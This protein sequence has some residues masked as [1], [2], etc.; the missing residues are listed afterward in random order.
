[1]ATIKST[2]I[3]LFICM[4]SHGFYSESHGPIPWARRA[5]VSSLGYLA[6]LPHHGRHDPCH[7]SEEKPRDREVVVV[8]ALVQLA[9]G[10]WWDSH[11]DCCR[12]MAVEAGGGGEAEQPQ[13]GRR[14]A[15]RAAGDGGQLSEENVH[16]FL[17]SGVA[18]AEV[19]GG[20]GHAHGGHDPSDPGKEEARDREEV[21]VLVEPRRR[22]HAH[23]HGDS[24]GGGEQADHPK[25]SRGRG[26]LLG[27]ADGLRCL[28]YASCVPL[29]LRRSTRKVGSPVAHST[30]WGVPRRGRIA[31]S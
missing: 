31:R 24:R 27:G 7:P 15:E 3:L 28:L 23:G 18:I 11:T 4:G 9:R 22:R 25:R 8:V 16:D 17:P 2:C 10:G 1:M 6:T 20:G 12:F 19:G 21:G 13:R 29:G 26:R 5:R 14:R 30:I